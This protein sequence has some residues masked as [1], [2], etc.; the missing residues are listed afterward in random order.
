LGL[1]WAE[2]RGKLGRE[3]AEKLLKLIA[4]C[5]SYA[6]F[7]PNRAQFEFS[8]EVGRCLETGR[9]IFLMTSGNG[10]GKSSGVIN[11]LLNIIKKEKNGWKDIVDVDSGD[12]IMGFYNYEFF[13]KYPATW[14]KKIWYVSNKDSL[15]SIWD[16]WKLWIGRDEALGGYHA[17]K[18]GKNFVSSVEFDEGWS[19]NFKTIDQEIETFESA[20]VGIIVFDEPPPLAI[21]K[22][23]WSRLRRGGIMII[24]ATPLFSASWFVDEIT[25]KANTKD[26]DK[27]WQKVPVWANCVEQGGTWRLPKL[28]DHPKGFLYEADINRTLQNYD[29]DELE[30][31]RDGEFKFLTGRVYKTY[32]S[33]IHFVPILNIYA[34]DKWNYMWRMVI[35]PHDRRPPA[36]IW[37]R[38]NYCM[39]WEVIREFPSIYDDVYDNAPFHKIKN[40]DPLTMSDFIKW[41]HK[42]ETKELRIPQNRI[43]RVIDPNFGNKRDHMTG[44]SIAEEYISEAGKIGWRIGFIRNVID[45]LA[46]GHKRVKELLKN[47]I[48]DIPN[49]VVG[50]RCFNTDY[51]MRNYS[52][53]E[54]AGKQLEKREISETVKEIGK[55]FADCIRYG[56]MVP[57]SFSYE[58]TD[59]LPAKDYGYPYTKAINSIPDGVYV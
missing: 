46:Q 33:K 16:E 3:K 58:R 25:S 22:A 13:R 38:I 37:M 18:D 9:R 59:L 30:A 31:R 43:D 49:L 28:G 55:D 41:M 35:D 45:E 52:Y 15:L 2:I 24:A 47:G 6:Y 36:I 42:I 1:N 40:A 27:Y 20:N 50:D 48:D 11:L 7:M 21:Y 34:Q 54:Y 4:E 10:A 17:S 12:K 57:V 51:A 8:R 19:M 23:C 44:M 14:P 56:A 26:S 53:D 39:K 29:P 5:P 32:D